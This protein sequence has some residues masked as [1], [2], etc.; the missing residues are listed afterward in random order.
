M[1][2]RDD[3][4]TVNQMIK[5]LNNLKKSGKGEYTI[6]CNNEYTLYNDINPVITDKERHVDF[7]GG[8]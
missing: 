3:Q 2:N 4:L 7:S 1:K 8:G 6:G 5:L